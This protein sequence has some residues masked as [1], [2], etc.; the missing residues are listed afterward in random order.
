MFLRKN[1][2]RVREIGINLSAQCAPR[3]FN[4]NFGRFLVNVLFLENLGARL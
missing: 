3:V 4:T 2:G 1:A